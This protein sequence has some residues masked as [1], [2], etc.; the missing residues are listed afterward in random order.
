MAGNAS[1]GLPGIPG[2]G[3][4]PTRHWAH[5]PS[6]NQHVLS[7]YCVSSLALILHQFCS[8]HDGNGQGGS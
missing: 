7:T 5:S 2:L 6:L 8:S 1:L 4:G 3:Q